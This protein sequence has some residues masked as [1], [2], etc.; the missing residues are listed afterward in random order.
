MRLRVIVLG[1]VL[2]VLVGGT[3]VVRARG[4]STPPPAKPT[5]AVL[6]GGSQDPVTVAVSAARRADVTARVLASGSVTSIRDSK[7]GSR[8][9]GRVAVVLVEENL[10][11]RGYDGGSLSQV[12]ATNVFEHVGGEWLMI[13]HHGSP[14]MAPADDEPPLQ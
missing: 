9:S 2:A 14:I 3:M 13:L 10:T 12:L 1:I 7:I 4:R 11:Q 8:L 5:A 6:H